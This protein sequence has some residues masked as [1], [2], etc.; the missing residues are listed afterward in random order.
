MGH[1]N[2]ANAGKSTDPITVD[3]ERGALIFFAETIGETNPVHRSV[4]AARGAGHPDVV[5]PATYA[6]VLDM[7]A[8]Q[9]ATRAGAIDALALVG[10]NMRYLLHGTEAYDYHAPIH[11]GD[12]IT[13]VTRIK[14]FTDAKGGKLEIAHLETKITHAERGD[15]VTVRRDLIHRLG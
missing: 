4:E 10:A 14:G 1:F 2:R 7:A 8:T 12:Q 9:D 3:V 5:A 15:L 11:A 6:A 13:V